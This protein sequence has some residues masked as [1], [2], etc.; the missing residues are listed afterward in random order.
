MAFYQID[1]RELREKR[2][3]LMELLSRFRTQKEELT[4]EE[5]ALKLMWEGEAN[6]NFHQMFI[7]DLGQMDAFIDI[8]NNFCE[9]MSAIADRYDMAERHNLGIASNRTY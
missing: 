6:D 3:Q 1:S 4:S 8:I 7:R 5:Q 2:D 9:V